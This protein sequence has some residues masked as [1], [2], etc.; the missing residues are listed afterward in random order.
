[1]RV[2]AVA[3]AVVVALAG[4]AALAAEAAKP[5]EKASAPA[6]PDPRKLRCVRETP[7][8]SSI[9]K[10]VC[11]TEEEW[12]ELQRMAAESHAQGRDRSTFCASAGK[13]C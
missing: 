6:K 11:Y 9:T 13:E 10:R 5:A 12:V 8:G 3:L 4:P 1:M 2:P 7:T